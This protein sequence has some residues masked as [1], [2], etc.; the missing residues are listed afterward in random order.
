MLEKSINDRELYTNLMNEIKKLNTDYRL[1]RRSRTYQLGVFMEQTLAHLKRGQLIKLARLY[2]KWMGFRR[3]KS[4]SGTSRKAAK[5]FS[6]NYF[7][8]ARIAV[9][10]VVFGNYDQILEPYVAPDNVDYWLIS[11]QE[12]D[13]SN[14]VWKRYDFS[15]FSDELEN[16]NNAGKNRFFKMNPHAVFPDYRYSLYIDGNIQIVSDITEYVYHLGTPGIAMHMHSSRD[17]VYE[18]ANAVLQAKKETKANIDAH[19]KYLRETGFPEHYGLLECNVIFRNSSEQCRSIMS[20][21]WAEYQ[22]RSKR[23]QL[24]FPYVLYKNSIPVEDVGTLGNNVYQ[25]PSF[26]VVTHN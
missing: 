25:N 10:T 18:E 7:C 19:M 17:C 11:D 9:Y 24:S 1:V 13:L 22:T 15:R 6:P 2:R 4:Y 8:D 23:D 14:S 3:A 20:D 16:L 26:R 5:S 12:I 21:W